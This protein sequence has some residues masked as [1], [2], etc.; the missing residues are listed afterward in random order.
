MASGAVSGKAAR[1]PF[2]PVNAAVL[3]LVIEQPTHTYDVARRFEDRFAGLLDVGDARVY[4]AMERLTAQ[5]LVEQLPLSSAER[6]RPSKPK[7]RN[8]AT[9]EGAR[10]HREWLAES[11]R[12]DP[13]RTQLRQRLLS[14]TV[15]DTT[16][17]L[18]VIS[19]Y[20]RAC[21]TQIAAAPVPPEDA[22]A[23]TAEEIMDSLRDRLFAELDRVMMQACLEWVAFGRAQT[24]MA[25]ARIRQLSEER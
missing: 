8:R 7:C 21:T 22:E 4:Q 3:A 17:V 11:M 10:T 24:Q 18:D 25:D 12:D 1:K 6:R 20:E 23:S 13:M 19:R 15:H 14:L 2:S 9:A 16:A 5:G